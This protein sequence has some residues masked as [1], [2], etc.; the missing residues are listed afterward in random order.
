MQEDMSSLTWLKVTQAFLEPP[1]PRCFPQHRSRFSHTVRVHK[2]AS[3]LLLMMCWEKT[4][5]F[6]YSF[7]SCYFMLIRCKFRRFACVISPGFTGG[8]RGLPSALYWHRK[9]ICL[10]FPVMTS[11]SA[12]LL[13]VTHA[14][15]VWTGDCGFPFTSGAPPR[16]LRCCNP[17]RFQNQTA[18]ERESPPSP[19]LR[20]MEPHLPQCIIVL[21]VWKS[22]WVSGKEC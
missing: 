7:E 16:R 8:L 19:L 12:R 15:L 1:L 4:G 21:L 10:A 11:A 18:P 3:F 9:S 2:N 17:A 13:P 22:C 20:T 6:N 14:A 5:L